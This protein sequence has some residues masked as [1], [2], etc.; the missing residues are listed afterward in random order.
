LWDRLSRRW[1]LPACACFMLSFNLSR[2]QLHH[3]SFI[4]IPPRVLT[5]PFAYWLAWHSP[6]YL[7]QELLFCILFLSNF[8]LF[9]LD[10]LRHSF[11]CCFGV[12]YLIHPFPLFC[13]LQPRR[14]IMSF[15]E[16]TVSDSN[17]ICI[18][19]SSVVTCQFEMQ[20]RSPLE[21]WTV[22]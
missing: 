5:F 4:L 8:K 7:L 16:F 12:H 9:V 14:V 21:I 22:K 20:C 15:C 3:S 6:D 17:S 2:V 13:F 11:Y 10:L 18:M 19:Y 1:R